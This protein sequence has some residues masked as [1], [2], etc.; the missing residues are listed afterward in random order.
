MHGVQKQG[1]FGI[2]EGKVFKTYEI[3]AL[4]HTLNVEEQ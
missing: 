3:S 2:V 4:S 1:L